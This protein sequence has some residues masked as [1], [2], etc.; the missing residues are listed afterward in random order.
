[1]EKVVCFIDRLD[2]QSFTCQETKYFLLM[3]IAHSLNLS[4]IGL[5]VYFL[6]TIDRELA[7]AI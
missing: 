2:L 1:M 5:R 4:E 3:L 7:V 6:A